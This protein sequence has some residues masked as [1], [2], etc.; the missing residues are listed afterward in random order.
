M[1]NM[2]SQNVN[3][4]RYKKMKNIRT[5]FPVLLIFSIQSMH[6][7][8]QLPLLTAAGVI[9]KVPGENLFQLADGEVFY[10]LFVVQIRQ[11]GPD[12]P[13]CRRTD[14]QSTQ[15]TELRSITQCAFPESR[16]SL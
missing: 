9:D 14:L 16:T 12:P 13:L 6:P 3:F 8:Q 11:R 1:Q 7:L 10:R 5:G 2:E 4:S 15:E